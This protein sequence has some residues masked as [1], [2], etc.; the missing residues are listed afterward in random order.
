MDPTKEGEV[1]SV[2]DHLCVFS[3]YFHYVIRIFL[4]SAYLR[5]PHKPTSE[6]FGY[7]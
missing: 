5:V 6:Y 2:C 7:M 1:G 3:S 4:N